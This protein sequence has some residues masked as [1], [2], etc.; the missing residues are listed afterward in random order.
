MSA[1]LRASVSL[2]SLPAKQDWYSSI[3]G[4]DMLGN[5][6]AGDCTIAGV[7][8]MAQQESIYAEVPAALMTTEEALGQYSKLSGWDPSKPESDTGLYEGDVGHHWM[9]DGFVIGGQ[10]DKIVGFA[11]CDIRSLNEILY[12]VLLTGNSMIALM[13]PRIAELRLD[14]WDVPTNPDD[15]QL[16]A[17][18]CVPVVGFDRSYWYCVSWGTLVPMTIPFAKKYLLEAHVTLSKRWLNAKN[19]TPAGF[20][21]DYL[22]QASKQLSRVAA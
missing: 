7:G 10:T 13:L 9:T 20:S 12:G 18:H 14:L 3:A 6:V 19:L 21:W 5:D 8:H 2:P 4:W 16:V 17:G 22:V 15:A 11:D 1:V